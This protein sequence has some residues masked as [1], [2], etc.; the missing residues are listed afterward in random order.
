VQRPISSAQD[1]LLHQPGVIEVAS[2]ETHS[3]FAN[4]LYAPGR[5]ILTLLPGG[6][7]DFATG[8]RSQQHK[9]AAS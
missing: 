6:H 3:A 5:E 2:A 4:A 9:L 7:Y 8:H 1:A